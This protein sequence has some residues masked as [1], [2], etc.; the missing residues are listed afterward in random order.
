MGNKAARQRF[1]VYL[2]SHPSINSEQALNPLSSRDR[3]SICGHVQ[4]YKRP[5]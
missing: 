2:A 5:Y 4:D 3:N 1:P